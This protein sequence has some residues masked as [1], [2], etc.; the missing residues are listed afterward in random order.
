MFAFGRDTWLKHGEVFTLVFG[1][2]ARFAPIEASDG[3]TIASW[4]YGRSA[5]G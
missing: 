2:F 5:P 4:R 1:T 3:P